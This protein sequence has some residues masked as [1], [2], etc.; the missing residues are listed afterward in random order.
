M[1]ATDERRPGMTPQ[2]AIRKFSRGRW[3]VHFTIGNQGFYIAPG[4]PK[5][6]AEFMARMLKLALK[7]FK[8]GGCLFAPIPARTAN[9]DEDDEVCYVR[10]FSEL[11]KLE[12]WVK[13][14]S[15][16]RSYQI[17]NTNMERNEWVINRN[18]LMNKIQKMKGE[19]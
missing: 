16:L 17:T 19:K 9:W 7:N 1:E 18:K 15:Y 11:N 5:K 10:Q 4:M 2:I 3:Y 14:N 13:A 12:R 8:K 6:E